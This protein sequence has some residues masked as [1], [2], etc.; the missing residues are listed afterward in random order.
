MTKTR[1]IGDYA[2]RKCSTN[3]SVRTGMRVLGTDVD[4]A[5]TKKDIMF[6]GVVD[7]KD[8]YWGNTFI[9]R[10]GRV[11]ANWEVSWDGDYRKW[12]CDGASGYLYELI[13]KKISWQDRLRL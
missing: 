13:G 6:I 1:Y 5:K 9:K 10:D 2:V 11:R 4:R 3:N 7:I 12:G 8:I